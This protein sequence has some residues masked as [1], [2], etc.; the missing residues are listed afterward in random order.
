MVVHLE[1]DIVRSPEKKETSSWHRQM[2]TPS[3]PI[4]ADLPLDFFA[5]HCQEQSPE[6]W[7]S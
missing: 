6:P 1:K 4:G 5:V 7:G 3:V 2:M